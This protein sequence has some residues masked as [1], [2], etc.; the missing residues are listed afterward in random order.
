MFFDEGRPGFDPGFLGVDVPMPALP[1]DVPTLLLNYFHFSVLFRPDRRFAAVTA[2]DLDGGHLVSLGRSDKWAL[3]PRLAAELQAGPAVYAHNDL[4]RG[5]L[6]RLASSAVQSV[7]S[8][9]LP[10]LRTYGFPD[11]SVRT[12]TSPSSAVN[13]SCAAC[14]A[15]TLTLVSAIDGI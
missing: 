12:A 6:V 4:D 14:D 2:L 1:P 13:A 8:P 9:T 11:W 3:D 10:L 7:M 15:T 5:H